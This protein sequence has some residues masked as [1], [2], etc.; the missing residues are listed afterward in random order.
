VK[1]Y[2]LTYVNP[3][4]L[5]PSREYTAEYETK[6]ELNRAL[7]KAHRYSGSFQVV[8]VEKRTANGLEPVVF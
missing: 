1:R 7:D 3:N 8:R 4:N 2:V 5:D 6:A